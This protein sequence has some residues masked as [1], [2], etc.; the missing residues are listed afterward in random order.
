V[1]NQDKSFE[2]SLRAR[3]AAFGGEETLSWI[4]GNN[5]EEVWS[6]FLQDSAIETNL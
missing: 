1:A 4:Y 3:I 2:S 6:K 5:I